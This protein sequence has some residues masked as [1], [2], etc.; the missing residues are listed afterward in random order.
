MNPETVV[1]SLGAS[2]VEM[3]KQYYNNSVIL[4]NYTRA[5]AEMLQVVQSGK[6]ID[7]EPIPSNAN[8]SLYSKA[9]RIVNFEKVIA[10]NTPDPEQA[11]D[12]K[13]RFLLFIIPPSAEYSAFHL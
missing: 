7:E 3:T 1:I 12:V 2:E 5:V 4:A 6:P 13:V 8:S 10:E 11:N 9:R